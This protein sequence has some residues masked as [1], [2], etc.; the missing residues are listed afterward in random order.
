MLVSTKE[1]NDNMPV[2]CKTKS[3]YGFCRLRVCVTIGSYRLSVDVIS[4]KIKHE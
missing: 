4:S 3:K 1:K 2:D